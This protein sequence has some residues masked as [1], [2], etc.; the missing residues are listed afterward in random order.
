M[1]FVIMNDAQYHADFTMPRDPRNHFYPEIKEDEVAKS[2]ISAKKVEINHTYMEL[3]NDGAEVQSIKIKDFNQYYLMD[4]DQ[5]IVLIYPSHPT[6]LAAKLSAEIKDRLT[7]QQMI[8]EDG[9]K[10]AI[11]SSMRAGPSDSGKTLIS[12]KLNTDFF[13]SVMNTMRNHT[14]GQNDFKDTDFFDK[15]TRLLIF[16]QPFRT[17]FIVN[18]YQEEASQIKIFHY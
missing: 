16:K 9:K 15:M 17:S 5:N 18:Q 1:K 14:E 13:N 8:E 11:H 12:R 10:V 7:E 6:D 2:K 4:E 3:I